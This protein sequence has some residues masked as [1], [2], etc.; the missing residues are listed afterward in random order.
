MN[1]I[2]EKLK[3][4]RKAKGYTLDDL[5]QM[6]KIQ[7]RYL[8][9]IEE[10]NYDVMPGKFYARAFIKQYADTVG[11]DGEQ[12]LADYTDSV[13]HTHDTEYVEQASANQTRSGNK[14]G[15]NLFEKIKDYLPSLFILVIVIVI[16][17]A[18][19]LAF[20]KT[21]QVVKEDMITKNSETVV[22]SSSESSLTEN[23]ESGKLE[24]SVAKK[25]E[26]KQSVSVVSSTGSQ[27]IFAVTGI[28]GVSE[29][30]LLA[31]GGDSWVS[32]EIDGVMVEQ[33]LLSSGN[34]LKAPVSEDV[35]QVELVVGNS[36]FTSIKLNDKNVEFAPEAAE[37]V[38][39][40]IEFQFN[41]EE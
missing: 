8:I 5:Q 36:K 32:I 28:S 35:K 18:I 15:N 12:L 10:N 11:L 33:A 24:S 40:K 31:E 30:N 19:Y 41:K 22:V 26:P 14:S 38:T 4:A 23:K 6:T 2:G 39:Q 3:E 21:N 13:P 1:E 29:I 37:A 16:V 34:S 25:E 9:A 7:K 20:I 27:T 17:T